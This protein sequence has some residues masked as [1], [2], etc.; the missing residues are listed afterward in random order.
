MSQ[1][2]GLRENL[3]FLAPYLM[4]KSMVSCKISLKPIQSDRG[5]PESSSDRGTGIAATGTNGRC[6]LPQRDPDEAREK[7]RTSGWFRNHRQ[8]YTMNMSIY[9]YIYIFSLFIYLVYSLLIDL[10][11]LFMYFIFHLCIDLFIHV[12]FLIY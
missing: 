11:Y 1:W 5:Y 2:I 10:S 6:Q 12:L 8:N 9:I 4:G 3:Q 7:S